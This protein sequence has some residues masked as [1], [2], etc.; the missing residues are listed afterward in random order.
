MEIL[1][2]GPAMLAR[3]EAM[4]HKSRG[5]CTSW[6]GIRFVVEEA[7]SF[8]SPGMIAWVKLTS[9]GEYRASREVAQ[10]VWMEGFME[11]MAE[12]LMEPSELLN[13]AEAC[14]SK[15]TIDPSFD[16]NLARARHNKD[17]RHGSIALSAWATSAWMVELLDEFGRTP[18][19]WLRSVVEKFRPLAATAYMNWLIKEL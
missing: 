19:E 12:E 1:S 18:D 8:S 17:V 7:H 2:F 5:I 15:M 13:A 11:R 10:D 14:S 3:D 9:F 16:V 6:D 4:R